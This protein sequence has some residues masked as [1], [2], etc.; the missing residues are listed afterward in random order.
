MKH[1][2]LTCLSVAAV[3]L[4]GT[5]LGSAQAFITDV[6]KT[7]D[8][9]Y[10]LAEWEWW[11]CATPSFDATQDHTGNGG[12]SLYI[13]ASYVQN[14]GSPNNGNQ[15]AVGE[16]LANTKAWDNSVMLDG[17]LYTNL[18]M[19]V[20]LDTANSTI[21]LSYWNTGGNGIGGGYG[22]TMQAL[23]QGGGGDWN[24]EALATT[25]FPNTVSNGWVKIN[26][27][28]AKSIQYLDKVEG[29]FFNKYDADPFNTGTFAFWVDDIQFEG[30][31]APPPPP[32]VNQLSQATPG[33]N[34]FFSTSGL[35]DRHE[36]VLR[37]TDVSWIGTATPANP[38]TYS[39]NI[40]GF[41]NDSSGSA[42]AY[43]FILPNIQN[44]D[45]APD[46]NQANC[47]IV[48]VQSNGKGTATMH[49]QYKINEAYNNAMYNGGSQTIALAGVST[50]TYYYTNAPG[51][52][53]YTQI[54]PGVTNISAETGELGNITNPVPFGTWTVKFTSD[55][56]VTLITPSG[57]STNF[58]IP[59]YNIST[60]APAGAPVTVYLGGQPNNDLGLYQSVAYSSFAISN[61]STP[62]TDNFL[63]DSVLDT[64][65][66]WNTSPSSGASGVLVVPAGSLYWMSWALPANGYSAVVSS[67]LL[68][69]LSWNAPVNKNI[70]VMNGNAMQIIS[71][72][73]VSGKAA[74][75]RL[76]QRQFTQ[77]QVLLPGETNA[78]NTLTGKVGTPTPV[79]AGSQVNVTI[80]AVDKTFNIVN[81]TDT[82]NL[83][84]TD[85]GATLPADSGLVGGTL[86]TS[87]LYLNDSGTWT[88]TAT[89]TTNTNI[90]AATSS[91]ITVQ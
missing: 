74:F 75:F 47:I 46:W 12:G 83:T 69:P 44:L 17:T 55:T 70:F 6:V 65:N 2:I 88:I 57:T 4:G 19:W 54:S 27:P 31:G 5:S 23:C 7:F 79:P 20:K 34:V 59:A 53:V 43:M 14:L 39:F 77:L 30:S 61:V 64:T 85:G 38:V 51:R 45:N 52:L 24:R 13:S 91:S 62:F 67:N 16:S 81:S 9:G 26:F 84:S 90:P 8:A 22:L 32:T 21:P 36:A 40:S 11:G 49:F 71:S 60:L 15:I 56:N 18:S 63:D 66:S 37:D 35:Y 86:T 78:P 10:P 72:N 1:K 82:I 73:D 28:F 76:I 87:A 89:D 29:L 68:A 58:T 42:E 25:Q 50:N 80:N 33:L 3:L 41:P 48:Y